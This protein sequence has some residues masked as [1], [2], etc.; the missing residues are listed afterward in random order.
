MMGQ[1][2]VAVKGWEIGADGRGGKLAV[3]GDVAED[4]AGYAIPVLKTAVRQRVGV[5]RKRGERLPSKEILAL[6]E[7]LLGQ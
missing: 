6:T 2:N 1:A 7:K 5:C 3:G 4:L